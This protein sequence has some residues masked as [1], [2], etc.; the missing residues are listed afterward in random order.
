MNGIISKSELI[1]LIFRHKLKII[2]IPLA[3]M[4]M[5]I[6]VMLF[7]PRTY[8][9]EA[10]LFLQIGRQ[11][12][13][14]DATASL[15][16]SAGLVQSN[17]DE[18]VKSALQVIGGRGVISQVVEEL[19]AEF[20]LSGIDPNDPAEDGEQKK[21][22]AILTTIQG[23]VGQVLGILKSIDPVSPKEDAV[24][25]IEN[26]LK[27]SAERNA[28]V[29]NVTF[30]AMSPKAA[31]KVLDTLIS[32]Y[33]SEHIRIHRN[34]QSGS[35]LLSERE[36]LLDQYTNV[37]QKVRNLK[38]ESGISSIEG[39]RV[40]I[41]ARIQM[42]EMEKIQSIQNLSSGRAR[43]E[44][45]KMQLVS[46]AERETSSQ[47]SV[48]NGG[49][50]LLRK[51]LYTSQIRMM[52]LK[53]RLASDHPQLVATNKQ[54]E[55]A[56]RLVDDQDNARQ[57]TVDD[58]NPIYR[59]LSLE[60][61]QQESVVAG[62]T[63]KQK[64]LQAQHAENMTGLECFNQ[65]AITLT[66]LEQEEQI[67]RDKYLQYT[68]SFEQALTDE[69]LETSKISS[70]S[71]AQNATL[72]ER[73]VSPSKPLLLLGGLFI[74]ISGVLGIVFLSENMNDR[75]RT[76]SDLSNLLGLPVLVTLP[77]TVQHRQVLAR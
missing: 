19:G 36:K 65:H 64:E 52:D 54:V 7:F 10:K 68:N 42:I 24:M 29:L 8:R 51:E 48:P 6:A 72:A 2:C 73:P 69:A 12:L 1:E 15:G 14:I 16:S 31:R 45:L 20:V 25:K 55:E 39:R 74:S 76:E 34:R 21:K 56:R 57:E 37:Q 67:A 22:N 9:S 75:I 27:F 71:I 49:A 59:A 4:V 46:I 35:F 41:E 32:V 62:L 47:K 13:G 23:G 77:D 66:Q 11:S 18:E 50:D 53:S 33:K 58:I 17:R 40:S 60:L 43:I 38:N 63:A 3:V 61:R 70:V 30:D 28:M 44:D 26:G 5:T